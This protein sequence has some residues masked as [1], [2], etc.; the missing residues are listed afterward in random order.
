LRIGYK[1]PR[2]FIP[3]NAHRSELHDFEIFVAVRIA[4]KAMVT[5]NS[6]KTHRIHVFANI[7]TGTPQFVWE[8]ARVH[9]LK[10]TAGKV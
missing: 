3:D 6:M 2:I 9:L 4:M 1:K 5:G 10:D 7:D 8:Q